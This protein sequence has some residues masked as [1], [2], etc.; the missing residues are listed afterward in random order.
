[1]PEA[2]K[3]GMDKGFTLIEVLGA[4]VL[5][6]IVFVAFMSLSGNWVLFEY[7]SSAE[8]KAVQVAE[9]ELRAVQS[10]PALCGGAGSPKTV[11][12]FTVRCHHD[13]LSVA[14]GGSYQYPAEMTGPMQTSLQSIIRIDNELR[15]VTVTVSWRDG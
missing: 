12:G 2:T 7:Q 1:M 14:A 8:K 6:G 11:N 9:K 4:V 13:L 3:C 5:L 15:L 10:N